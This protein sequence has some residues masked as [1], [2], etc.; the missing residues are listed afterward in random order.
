VLRWPAGLDAETFMREHWQRRPLLMRGALRGW[1][2]PLAPRALKQL[3][4]RAE[5]EARIVTRRGGRWR[6]VH[7]P[8]AGAALAA[9][10]RPHSTLL[11]QGVDL[12]S[13]AAAALLDCVRFLPRA[14][15]DDLMVS[16]ARDGGGVGPHVDSYDVFLVQGSGRRRWRIAERYDPAEVDGAPLRLLARFV[17]ER[18]YLLDAGDILYLPPGV[19]HDGIAVGDCTTWSIGFR[20]PDATDLA[21]EYVEQAIDAAGLRGLLND[22]GRQPTRHPARIDARYLRDAHRLIA[23]LAPRRDWLE[24]ALGRM[25]T[26]PR[27][28][29]GFAAPARPLGPGS[30]A[31]RLRSRGVRLDRATRLLYTAGA[32][33]ANGERLPVPRPLRAVVERLADDRLLPPGRWPEPLPRLLYPLYLA[34]QLRPGDHRSAA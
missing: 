22:A 11:V 18:E 24:R 34:G 2:A 21:R 14:R 7:A 23:P 8:F 6:V 13:D 1:R 17:P 28:G 32:V 5:V 20:A 10:E 25:L 26:E 30:F 33:Y 27:P 3:A 4:L 31:A 19:A 12:L 29:I 15:L 9:L 16:Y